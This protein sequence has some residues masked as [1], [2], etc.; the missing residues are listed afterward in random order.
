MMRKN[1]IYQF[2]EYVLEKDTIFDLRFAFAFRSRFVNHK[3]M[4]IL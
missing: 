3:I 4:D 2:D 1:V